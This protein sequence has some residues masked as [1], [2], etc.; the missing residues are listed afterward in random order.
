MPGL[1]GDTPSSIKGG[2]KRLN[3]TIN[4]WHHMDFVKFHKGGLTIHFSIPAFL[5]LIKA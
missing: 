5:L 3:N 2:Q 4:L 1:K